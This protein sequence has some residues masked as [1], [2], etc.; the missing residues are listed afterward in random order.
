MAPVLLF[1][2]FNPTFIANPVFSGLVELNFELNRSGNQYSI[3][4]SPAFNI[5]NLNYEE[6]ET[7]NSLYTPQESEF[8]TSSLQRVQFTPYSQQ[9]WVISDPSLD[10]LVED[11]K[12]HQNETN[13]VFSL[14]S[15]WSFTRGLPSGKEI[16]KGK[17]IVE[18]DLNSI[19]PFIELIESEKTQEKKEAK[20]RV[21]GLFPKLLRLG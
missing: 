13:A 6:E 1:S 21:L 18:L 2:G 12:A 15:S 9:N 8:T 3:F 5:R 19:T 4:Q 7:F 16:A 20:I 17:Q 10:R 14:Q 11:F